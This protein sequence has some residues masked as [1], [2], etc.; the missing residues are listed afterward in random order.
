M[1]SMK[2][3]LLAFEAMCYI[4]LHG[5]LHGGFL[6]SYKCYSNSRHFLLQT[7]ALGISWKA[8]FFIQDVGGHYR[9]KGVSYGLTSMV[10]VIHPDTN[11]HNCNSG[12][13][14]VVR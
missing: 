4:D 5:L 13:E 12:T 9:L 2:T 14:C 1:L 10:C 3:T 7:L 11:I 8:S 6:I